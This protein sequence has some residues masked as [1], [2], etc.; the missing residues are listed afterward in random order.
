MA[1]QMC[2]GAATVEV[3]PCDEDTL[4]PDLDWLE[5]LFLAQRDR[6]NA[7]ETGAVNGGGDGSGSGSSISNSSAGRI[8][9]G[10]KMH[11]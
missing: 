4:L 8:Q 3:G 1:A 2:G 6:E 10:V 7:G 9:V 5:D 11:A